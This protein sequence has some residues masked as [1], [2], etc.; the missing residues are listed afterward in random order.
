MDKIGLYS[1]II[2][3]TDKSSIKAILRTYIQ[4]VDRVSPQINQLNDIMITD[5]SWN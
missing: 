2:E 1:L 5:F 3:V 4:I